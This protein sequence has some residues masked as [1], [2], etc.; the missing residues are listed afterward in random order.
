M[1]LI[2][3]DE[4]F[5]EALD[6]SRQGFEFFT[7]VK[8]HTDF[9][10]LKLPTLCLIEMKEYGSIQCYLAVATRKMAVSTFDSRLTI[11]KLP[12][13]KSNFFKED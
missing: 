6:D 4:A 1:I 5:F 12:G 13:H 11:K 9:Q 3:F 7:F 8:P 2:R 10:D